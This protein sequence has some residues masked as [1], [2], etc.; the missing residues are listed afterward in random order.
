MREFINKHGTVIG[1]ALLVAAALV[2]YFFYLRKG[3]GPTNLAYYIDEETG[4]E[5]IHP[6]TDLPPLIGKSG[7]PTVVEEFKFTCDGGSTVKVA[8]YFKFT[9][10][11]K[12]RFDDLV[13]SGKKPT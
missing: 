7:R 6:R 1:A 4:E 2:I 8:Y 5:S 11:A 3:S 12:K 9:D 13:A 10:S